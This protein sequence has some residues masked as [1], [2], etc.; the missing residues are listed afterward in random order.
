[1]TS[2]IFKTKPDKNLLYQLLEH[3]CEP[4]DKTYVVDNVAFK[5]GLMFNKIVEYTNKVERYYYE[6]KKFYLQRKMTY[7]YFLTIIRQM[8]KS[9]EIDYSMNIKYNKSSYEIIYHIKKEIEK[10]KLKLTDEE[11][12]IAQEHI[13][14]ELEQN[15]VNTTIIMNNHVDSKKTLTIMEK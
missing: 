9:N 14:K 6:S 1:M 10:V 5:R 4:H 15:K 8:C 7:K 11:Q 3:I 13:N 2:Q 12:K